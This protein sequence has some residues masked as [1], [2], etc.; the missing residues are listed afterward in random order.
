MSRYKTLTTVAAVLLLVM[1]NQVLA[2]FHV[3]IKKKD[4]YLL[5]SGF[6]SAWIN[7]K[8]GNKAL[9]A[10]PVDYQKALDAYKYANEYNPEYAPLNLRIGWCHLNLQH[11][12]EAIASIAKAKELKNDVHPAIDI[13]LAKAYHLN[14]QF[15]EAIASYE[16]FKNT[17]PLKK[18]PV[19]DPKID[20]LIEQ[21]EH[22]KEILGDKQ[23]LLVQNAG[24][25]INTPAPEYLPFFVPE[26]N[27]LYFTSQRNYTKSADI[28]LRYGRYYEDIYSA[29]YDDITGWESVY[30]LGKDFNN[31]G[32]NSVV[33]VLDQGHTLLIYDGK[34]KGGD[35]FI[36]S[37]D[38]TKS[39]WQSPKKFE[40]INTKYHESGASLTADGNTI[41]YIANHPKEGYGEHDIWTTT[42]N[43]KGRWQKPSILGGGINSVYDEI[44][45]FVSPD[46]TRLYF[47][48]NGHTTMGGYDIFVCEKTDS[49]QWSDPM[50]LGYPINTP[51]DETSFSLINSREAL[52]SSRRAGGY[53]QED[54]Y[55]I[56]F[57]GGEKPYLLTSSIDTLAW[58]KVPFF[59]PLLEPALESTVL[60]GVITNKQTGGPVEAGIEIID[61]E[62]NRVIYNAKSDPSS[63]KYKV[64][65]PA[66][67][68]FSIAVK[69]SDYMIVSDNIDVAKSSQFQVIS[70][71]Y[72]LQ[73][74]E[75]GAKLILR[76]VFFDTGKSSLRSES[77]AEL[78]A[79]VEFMKINQ[80]IKVEI[81]GHTDNIGGYS[82][83]LLLSKNRAKA[84]MDYMLTKGLDPSR[85]VSTGYA[86]KEPVASN[87]TN[88]GRQLNRRVEAKVI[89]K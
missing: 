37:Y 23:R 11:Y 76:N 59:E 28:N 56:I 78:D 65:L 48:S 55:N 30:R 79:L 41:F 26:T 12:P 53:G 45:V 27:V 15:D 61:R 70:R 32:N 75:I 43:D 66:G 19:E 31:K 13:L 82:A 80:T 71:N 24:D 88:D 73:P 72:A 63:G 84:V 20:R 50:N 40:D 57:L 29:V 51:D 33:G 77:Y 34:E 17:I 22:G 58:E 14:T 6:D 89:G 42:K 86:D 1:F 38:T 5:E 62:L 25:S 49:L 67:K 83:N 54:I 21:C 36:A 16:A 10:I 85:L 69:A 39:K 52:V 68:N 18:K 81:G 87:K 44:S 46:G 3:P 9:R 2:Q 64:A 47:A 7:I 4:F 74:I 35:I 60:E 8:K